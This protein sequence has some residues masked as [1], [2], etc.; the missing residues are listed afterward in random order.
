MARRNMFRRKRKMSAAMYLI[1][2][3]SLILGGVAV[4]KRQRLKG[5]LNPFN[6]Y[7]SNKLFR[8]KNIT[9]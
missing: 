6:A 9:I 4:R 2:G 8:K 7:V 3:A 5:L 1:T